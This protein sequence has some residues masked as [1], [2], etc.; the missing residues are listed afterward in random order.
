VHNKKMN[1]HIIDGTSENEEEM[2]NTTAKVMN[3]CLI[4]AIIVLLP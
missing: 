2:S 4:I 3:K 1:D